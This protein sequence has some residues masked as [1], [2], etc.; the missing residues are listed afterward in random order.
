VSLRR[1]GDELL[2]ANAAYKGSGYRFEVEEVHRCLDEGLIE[3]PK[4]PW[5]DTLAVMETMDE[6]RSQIGVVFPESS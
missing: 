2:S 4:R 3:S 6:I 1:E 5:A